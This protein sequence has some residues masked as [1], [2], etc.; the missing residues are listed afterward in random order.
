MMEVTGD[1]IPHGFHRERPTLLGS[2]RSHVAHFQLLCHVFMT[3]SV[4]LGATA[5]GY[6]A[7]VAW[8]HGVC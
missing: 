3:V 8:Q 5:G 1:H 4:V 7:P 6:V 2:S